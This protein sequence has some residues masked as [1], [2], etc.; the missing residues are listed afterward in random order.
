MSCCS[1]SPKK[2]CCGPPSNGAPAENAPSKCG[3]SK[4]GPAKCGPGKCG[5][6]QADSIKESVKDYYGKRLKNTDDLQTNACTLNACAMPKHI[7][8][9]LKEVHP[10]IKK[11]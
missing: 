2:P 7:R 10:E 1:P 5:D 9:A 8:E 11:R 4:C 6:N 3:P